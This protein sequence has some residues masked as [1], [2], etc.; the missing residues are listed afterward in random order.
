[1]GSSYDAVI[2]GA[3]HNGLVCAAYLARAGRSVLVLERRGVV[4]GCAVTEEFAPGFRC[5][6]TFAGVETFDPTIAAE[7]RLADHGLRLLAPGGVLVP[8]RGA[9][10]L[11]L[12]PS[13]GVVDRAAWAEET[14]CSAAD[15]R[16]F[17]DF[18]GF[19]R[20]LAE[21]VAPILSKPLPELG[22]TG[23]R[24]LL[25]LAGTG[26]LVRRLGARDLQ[27][28]MRY[29][30]MPLADVLDERF[31]SAALKAAIGAGGLT[32]SWLAPRSP[33]SALNLLLHR[34]GGCRGALGFPRFAAGG[35]GALCEALRRAAEAAGATIR[36]AAEVSGI[37]V[38][39]G[40][41]SGVE[42]DTGE[43]IPAP[44]VVSNADP[45][46]TLLRLVSPCELDPSF[47]MAVQAIRCRGT[48]AIV[49][50]ALAGLPEFTGAA[51]D[52]HRLAGRIQIGADLD[53]L[54]RAFDDVKYGRLPERPY[55]DLTIPSIADPGLAP[56]GRHVLS[57]WVQY[58]PYHL[59]GSGWDEAR[60]TLADT[61]VR[62]I[63]DHAPGLAASVLA[64]RTLSPLDLE[65]RFGV[66]EG[67]LYHAEPALDQ[68]LYLRPVP[69]WARHRMPIEGLYLCGSG[70]HGGGGLT[71]LAGRNAARRVLGDA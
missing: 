70:T 20:R 50:L 29:L 36:T 1:M 71:G 57:A 48:V 42:L 64:R 47:A 65:R 55:L 27:E 28:A 21:A 41:V 53:D 32:G 54:E 67:C 18:E 68:C 11:F 38:K 59:R 45:K 13:E 56:E 6:A 37:R 35:T 34:L 31:E 17:S 15:T 24:G 44:I 14:G 26:W 25:D 43:R 63:E 7:L 16:A 66:T 3:G 39:R 12:P 2:V 19:L 23:W 4:G 61:V 9:E 46:A 49:T 69:G 5:S 62:R 22:P 40:A 52:P 8:R 60:E 33:G 51:H 30:P 10:A 58:P